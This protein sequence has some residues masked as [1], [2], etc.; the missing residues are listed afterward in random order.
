[1]KAH[2]GMR[3]HDIVVLLK[4]IIQEENW[5]SKDIAWALKISPS[6]ISESLSRSSRSGL[7]SPDKRKV[8]KSAFLSFLQFGL[9]YVFP[10]EPGP[11]MR[12]LPTAHSAGILK[13]Y[14][15]SKEVYVWPAKIGKARGQSIAPLYPGQIEAVL[16]D[17]KLYDMLAL[18]DGMRIG[19]V[20]ECEKSI[21]LLAEIFDEAYA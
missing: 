20:R 17:P 3:P 5:L 16:L 19:R 18:V 1:M 21:E 6:E 15:V 2:N 12:G 7:L 10:A 4:I 8:M 11:I 13:E 9:R 14:L